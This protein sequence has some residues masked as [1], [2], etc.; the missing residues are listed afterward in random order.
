MIN[1]TNRV[2]TI[3]FTSQLIVSGK[4]KYHVYSSLMTY[5]ILF[6]IMKGFL[7]TSMSMGYTFH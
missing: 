6:D 7:D 1:E 4:D 5:W 3:S 2:D